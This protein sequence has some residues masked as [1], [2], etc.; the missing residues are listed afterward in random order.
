MII[1]KLRHAMESYRLKTGERITYQILSEKT[2]ISEATL[3]TI[4]SK[5]TYNPSLNAID[6]LCKA[7]QC[8]V[9]DILEYREDDQ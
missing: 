5:R 1:V 4:G 9:P 3:K 8:D 2:G 7:L 6:A